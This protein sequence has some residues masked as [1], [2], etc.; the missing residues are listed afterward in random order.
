MFLIF[1]HFR[2]HAVYAFV[3]LGWLRQGATQTGSSYSSVQLTLRQAR[4]ELFHVQRCGRHS[5]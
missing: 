2:L 4:P 5:D 1:L 3:S